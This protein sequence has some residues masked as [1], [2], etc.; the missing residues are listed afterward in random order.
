MFTTRQMTNVFST[1]CTAVENVMVLGLSCD[2]ASRLSE[3]AAAHP[4]LGL[5]A[6]TSNL[7]EKR[8]PGELVATMSPRG[9][10]GGSRRYAATRTWRIQ[11]PVSSARSARPVS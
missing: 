6:A 9:T 4:V 10:S 11:R 2:A 3:K 7:S 8:E 1:G 5:D